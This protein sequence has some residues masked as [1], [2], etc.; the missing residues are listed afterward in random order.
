MAK[1]EKPK[2]WVHRVVYPAA[3]VVA[4]GATGYYLGSSPSGDVIAERSD[5]PKK[6]ETASSVEPPDSL[7]S[8]TKTADTASTPIRTEQVD[9]ATE[10][11]EAIKK[12]LSD[13][14]VILGLQS[15]LLPFIEP[16]FNHEDHDPNK[17]CALILKTEGLKYKTS[18]QNLMV[19]TIRR[20]LEQH[21]DI[22]FGS[23]KERI[24]KNLQELKDAIAAERD[25][26]T[27]EKDDKARIEKATQALMPLAMRFPKIYNE[28]KADN[29]AGMDRE[30]DIKFSGNLDISGPGAPVYI[31][32]LY[33][34]CEHVL[35]P[36]FPKG[37]TTPINFS[38]LHDELKAIENRYQQACQNNMTQEQ[39]AEKTAADALKT[40][41]PAQLEELKRIN[42]EKADSISSLCERYGAEG[43]NALRLKYPIPIPR[44]PETE[45][46]T[47]PD[48]WST[49]SIESL[50]PQVQRTST[51]EK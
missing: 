31:K 21:D 50:L 8:K 27:N 48:R 25:A 13:K 47:A 45:I 4:G 19:T 37:Q 22:I 11:N 2:K 35:F 49:L 40:L 20:I 5:T 38:A 43:E 29:P 24:E 30:E 15:D 51:R 46:V 42:K 36:V 1:D 16:D 6:P 9:A 34:D 28:E 39:R 18:I 7:V 12:V 41:T 10:Q 3:L 14:P 44:F 17:R 33:S 26:P 23:E 32:L